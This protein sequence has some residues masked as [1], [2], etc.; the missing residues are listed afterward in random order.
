MNLQENMKNIQPFIEK[1]QNENY[2]TLFKLLQERIDY[3]ESFV[4]VLGE[5]SSGKSTLINGLLGQEVIHTSAR[6]TTGTIV[7]LYEYD[8]DGQIAPYAVLT[9]AKLRKLTNEQ[10]HQLCQSPSED[11]LRLRLHIP[12]MPYQLQGM[13]LF[14]TP[15]YGSIHEQHEEVLTEFVPNSDVI[16][17]VVNYRVGIGEQDEAFIQYISNYLQ[18]DL[19]FFLVINRVPEELTSTDSR[20]QEI[21]SYARNLLH[22]DVQHFLVPTITGNDVKLPQATGLWKAV[23]QEIQSPERQQRI[24]DVLLNYQIQLLQDIQLEWQKKVASIRLSDESIQLAQQE[25]EKLKEKQREAIQLIHETFKKIDDQLAKVFDIAKANMDEAITN[26]IKNSNKWTSAEECT[27]YT[28]AHLMPRY[29]KLERK[30]IMDFIDQEIT[31]L[32]DKLNELINEAYINFKRNIEFISNDFEPMITSFSKKLSTRTTDT[33]LKSFLAKF[34]GR[35]GAGAGVANLGKKV[36]KKTGDLFGKKF[37]RDQYNQ[38][39]KILKK[40]GATST[41]N[42][43]I[44]VTVILEGIFFIIEVNRWQS[45]LLKDVRKGLDKWRDDT[46]REV[47]KD[48]TNLKETNVEMVQEQFEELISAF[49]LLDNV[50]EVEGVEQWENEVEQIEQQLNE[51]TKEYEE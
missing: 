9:N 44:A 41:R 20:V 13:R 5:T 47:K 7:E 35:G 4:T 32:N 15:G 25:L 6:P 30:K 26:E 43:T 21:V 34:G 11:I 14:D 38:L 46:L 31:I 8:F 37:T 2:S 24:H 45:R 19:T 17:Y 40:I 42:L 22:K 29:E 18:D 28:T 50:L 36:M 39:A 12:E 51:M 27:G 1:L 33:L 23:R 3:P 10:F 16:I 48:M 49:N